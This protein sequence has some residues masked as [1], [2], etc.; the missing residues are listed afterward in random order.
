MKSFKQYVIETDESERDIIYYLDV[1]DDLEK[2][3]MSLGKDEFMKR[4]VANREER[5]KSL[6]NTDREDYF[7][8]S[9]Y[10]NRLENAES[11][12]YAASLKSMSDEELYGQTANPNSNLTSQ[13]KSDLKMAYEW[14]VPKKAK[15]MGYNTGAASSWTK[16]P[17]PLYHGSK[18]TESLTKLDPSGR[19]YGGV[20]FVSESREW[21]RTTHGQNQ[22]ANIHALF[23]KGPI[24][25]TNNDEHRKILFDALDEKQTKHL[26]SVLND[27]KLARN[28]GYG[29]AAMLVTTMKRNNLDEYFTGVYEREG[30]TQDPES[31]FMQFRNAAIWNAHK[32][33]KSADPITYDDEGNPIPLHKRFDENNPDIRY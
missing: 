15:E 33:I 17:I 25:D 20:L 10:E 1:E 21:I 16:E 26:L 11:G 9:F 3:A 28:L 2:N 8:V 13:M 31:R 4:F 22:G 27:N 12:F 19:R 23:V 14:R 29:D 32:N 5:Y 7:E 24:F 6:N 18:D 30:G